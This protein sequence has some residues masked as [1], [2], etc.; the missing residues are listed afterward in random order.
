[1][2]GPAAWLHAPHAAYV[3]AAYG[4]SAAVLAALVVEA[5]LRARSW[6]RRAER[7]GR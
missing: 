2:T 6:R 3:Q 7:A 1:M 4:T 5:L